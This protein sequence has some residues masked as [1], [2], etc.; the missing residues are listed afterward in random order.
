M[1]KL[2]FLSSFFF[3]PSKEKLDKDMAENESRRAKL[4]LEATEA[5]EKANAARE[6]RRQAL[7]AEAVEQLLGPVFPLCF[8]IFPL[9]F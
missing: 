9:L 3:F 1:R 4:L 2:F 7:E 5:E 8:H 6:A